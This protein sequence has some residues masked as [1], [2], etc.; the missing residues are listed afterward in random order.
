MVSRQGRLCKEVLILNALYIFLLA[1]WKK[2][3]VWYKVLLIS[4][5]LYSRKNCWPSQPINNTMKG[6]FFWRRIPTKIMHLCFYTKFLFRFDSEIC[7][8]YENWLDIPW[9]HKGLSI[10]HLLHINVSSVFLFRHGVSKISLIYQ[11]K[12][13]VVFCKLHDVMQLS[14]KVPKLYFQSQFS[15]TKINEYKK[16][17][18]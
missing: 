2:I 12:E 15:I 8:Y 1:R 7:T 17:S 10:W 5:Q 13:K 9:N 11:K 14:W 6:N 16:K 4:L 3:K 18:I